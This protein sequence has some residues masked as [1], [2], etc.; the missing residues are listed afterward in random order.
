MRTVRPELPIIKIDYTQI[1][2]VE[3][4][5][6][7]RTLTDAMIRFYDDPKN[8][9]EFEEWQKNRKQKEVETSEKNYSV[10]DCNNAGDRC[11]DYCGSPRCC[12]T[13]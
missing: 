11:T 3:L 8:R 10:P 7:F 4:K 1:P 13:K 12:S 5:S 6:L 9:K 2:P